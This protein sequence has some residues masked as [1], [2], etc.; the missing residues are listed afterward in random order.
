MPKLPAVLLLLRSIVLPPCAAKIL[1]PVNMAVKINMCCL[2][3]TDPLTENTIIQTH[4]TE[5]IIWITKRSRESWKIESEKRW[6]KLGDSKAWTAWTP[7]EGRRDEERKKCGE[8]QGARRIRE[9]KE[10][11]ISARKLELCMLFLIQ[12]RRRTEKNSAAYLCACVSSDD[13]SVCFLHIKMSLA[14]TM[15]TAPNFPSNLVI[16]LSQKH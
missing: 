7:K 10:K 11:A 5:I 6:K 2:H 3:A 12:G 15:E 9:Q 8:I 16:L 4:Y 1:Q 13:S 14:V